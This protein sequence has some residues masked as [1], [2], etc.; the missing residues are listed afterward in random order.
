L[1]VEAIH[2]SVAPV[3]V[4]ALEASPAGLLGAVASPPQA[5]VVAVKFALLE[6]LPA[7]SKAATPSVY[8]LPQTSPV[9]V[10]FV[11]VTV[12]ICAPSR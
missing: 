8:A 9:K 7:A 5:V 12:A 1:S 6:T 4:T 10:K 2:E 3:C 11:P